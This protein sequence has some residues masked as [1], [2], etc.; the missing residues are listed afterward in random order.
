MGFVASLALT[1]GTMGQPAG[2][3]EVKNMVR[4]NT[5]FAA[6]LYGQLAKQPGNL[7]FSPYS[8]SSAL[9]MTYGGARGK[10]AQEMAT[11]L[12]FNMPSEKVHEAFAAINSQL[13]GDGKRAFALS[14]ANALWAQK[15]YVFHPEFVQLTQKYYGAGFETVDFRNATE[16]ARE[17][18]NHWVEK[19]THDKIKDLLPTGTLTPATRLVLTNAIYFKAAWEN[20]FAAAQT[21]PAPF[22]TGG[23]EIDVSMMHRLN[24]TSYLATDAF[25][26][27]ELPYQQE[28][29]SLIVLLPKQADGLG[30]VERQLNAVRL[31]QWLRDAKRYEVDTF[32]PKFKITAQFKLKDVLTALGMG[33]AFRRGADFTGMSTAEDLV[34]DQVIHKAFIDLDEKGTEA[35]A[36]TAVTIRALG[37]PVPEKLERVTFRADHPFMFLIRENHTGSVLFM[38]RLENPK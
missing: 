13:R 16:E 32:L 34:I 11:T 36:A 33:G 29:L 25:Q 30:A 18:I 38:G 31:E 26:M 3:T 19:E 5:Q 2:K 9:A 6:D 15:G 4:D 1:A 7:F 27:L 20:A 23:K 28:E 10:T 37:A 17:T 24:K 22:T 8:I 12:H 35:A 21:K 14:V